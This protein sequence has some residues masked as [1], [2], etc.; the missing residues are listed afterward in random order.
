M[1]QFSEFEKKIINRLVFDSPESLGQSCLHKLVREVLCEYGVGFCWDDEYGK[2]TIKAY[3][4]PENTTSLQV[5]ENKLVALMVLIEYLNTS[6]LLC[7]YGDDTMIR[8]SDDAHIQCKEDGSR[9]VSH[10]VSSVVYKFY[11]NHWNDFFYVS[12]ELRHIEQDND[13]KSSEQIYVE[14]QLAEAKDQTKLAI[15]TFLASV[16]IPLIVKSCE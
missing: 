5:I 9:L 8:S 16:I 3:C 7:L 13:F 4:P 11:H 14:K 1:R 10:D 12:D 15:L 6:H 2:L